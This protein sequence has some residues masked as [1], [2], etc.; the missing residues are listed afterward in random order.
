M[1]KKKV[2]KLYLKIPDRE[3]LQ[4]SREEVIRIRI[5]GKVIENRRR[6]RRDSFEIFEENL[7]IGLNVKCKGW[8]GVKDNAKP[9]YLETRKSLVR[10]IDVRNL[11]GSGESYP[12][13]V[14]Q[15]QSPI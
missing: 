4:L 15:K 12:N 3:T 8:A 11:S 6:S 10:K 13:G 14:P 1:K 9:F 7:L 5:I 2:E